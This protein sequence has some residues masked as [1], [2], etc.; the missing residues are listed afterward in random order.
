MNRFVDDDAWVVFFIASGV[1]YSNLATA[2]QPARSHPGDWVGIDPADRLASGSRAHQCRS[3][4]LPVSFIGNPLAQVISGLPWRG[5]T[6]LRHFIFF[7]GAGF[8]VVAAAPYSK[9]VHMLA[10]GITTAMFSIPAK[11]ASPALS[12]L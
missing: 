12:Y 2:D 6:L 9:W 10:A 5:R 3:N 4:R 8:V 11:P 1:I 7:T